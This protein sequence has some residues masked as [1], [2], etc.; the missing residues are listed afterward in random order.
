MGKELPKI[1]KKLDYLLNKEV[2]VSL[3]G[4]ATKEDIEKYVS[5]STQRLQQLE[6]DLKKDIENCT[7]DQIKS[8]QDLRKYLE[9]NGEQLI[10]INKAVENKLN[11]I[12]E[13]VG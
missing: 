4:L 3:S 11:S 12:D 8:I 1:N 2:Q 10:V 7:E 13:A 5:Y 9:E 6:S